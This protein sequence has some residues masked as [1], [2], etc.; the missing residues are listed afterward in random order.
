MLTGGYF[1]NGG[2]EWEVGVLGVGL[3]INLIGLHVETQRG[4]YL[5]EIVELVTQ[6]AQVFERERD[7]LSTQLFL[8]TRN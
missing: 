7:E 2:D 1:L 4:E 3:V 5:E 6:K 8:R